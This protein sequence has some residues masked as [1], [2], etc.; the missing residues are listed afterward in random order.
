[1]N[2]KN[3]FGMKPLLLALLVL[4]SVVA[5]YAVN[6]IE[7]SAPRSITFVANSTNNYPNGTMLNA[8]RGYIFTYN[9]D[10]RAPTFKWIGYVGNISGSYALQDSNGYR[11]YN[12]NL[13]TTKGEVYATKEG[14][15]TDGDGDDDGDQGGIPAWESISCAN[16]GNL[17][18]EED[19][20]NHTTARGAKANEDSYLNTFTVHGGTWSLSQSF[21]VGE[22]VQVTGT[23]CYGLNTYT[24]D[25]LTSGNWDE[26]ALMDGTTEDER[27]SGYLDK[28]YDIIYASLI[29]NNTAGYNNGS[30][31][32]FQI[33]LPQSGLE[34]SQPNKAFF[35]YIELI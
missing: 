18:W 26:V 4:M 33:M 34:G 22:E 17:T 21:Y 16:L 5:V 15:G 6:T 9:I 30:T 27:A 13:A 11:L 2:T 32:D 25:T 29:E 20:F 8:T 19:L 12:W 10:E 31:Y 14:P 7:P 24:N 23:G 3:I 28:Q 1:M 35:F